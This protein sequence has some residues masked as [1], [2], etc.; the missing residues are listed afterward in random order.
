[1]ERRIWGLKPKFSSPSGLVSY[2]F[3]VHRAT[4]FVPGI[5]GAAAVNCELPLDN[6]GLWF[7]GAFMPAFGTSE[8]LCLAKIPICRRITN[9][10]GSSYLAYLGVK[11][12]PCCAC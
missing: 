1:V 2:A 9:I 7:R 6:F 12:V 10:Y 4:R 11:L 5:N 3:R 8:H